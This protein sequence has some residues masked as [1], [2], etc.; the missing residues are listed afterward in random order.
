[1]SKIRILLIFV[2][3]FQ[4]LNAQDFEVSPLVMNF[5]AEPGVIQKK[6]LT[7]INHSAQPQKYNLKISDFVED[8][9]GNRKIVPLGSSKRSCAN[10]LNISPSYIQLNPNQKAQLEITMSVPKDSFSSRWCMLHVEVAKDQSAFEADKSVVA[11]VLLVP[12][13]AVLVNQSPQSNNIYKATINE[14]KEITKRGSNHHVFEVVV[15]NEGDNL[16]EANVNLTLV[17]QQSGKEEKF[18]V[19]KATVYPDASRK[20]TLQMPSITVKGNYVV[21]AVVDYG[22]RQPLEETK[23]MLEIK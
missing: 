8:T 6:Q 21:T 13:I 5:N 18:T 12:R 15:A 4:G 16:I 19:T 23:L 3:L 20:I 9:E 14:L 7:L 10:W 22:H 17:N 1:M 2:I 11:G